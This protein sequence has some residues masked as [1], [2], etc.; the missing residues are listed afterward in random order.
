MPS[1]S[2]NYIAHYVGVENIIFGFD[3]DILTVMLVP[4][5]PQNGSGTWSLIHTPLLEHERLDEA[6]KRSLKETLGT[7]AAFFKQLQAFD[8]Q[9]HA[10]ASP[11]LEVVYLS[12]VRM[13]LLAKKAD[14]L[15]A[16]KYFP[17]DA[18]PPLL[19]GHEEKILHALEGL[20]DLIRHQPVAFEL[21]PEKF[22]IPQLRALYESIFGVTLD[23]G[24]FSKKLHS[25]DLLIRLDEKD[26]THSRKGAYYYRYS[27]HR[28]L[29]LV[30]NGFQFELK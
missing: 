8:V 18:L 4:A 23:H 7:E 17:L 21:L 30:E 22:T 19:P 10:S 14:S 3:S 2:D 5:D 26:K 12:L 29:E 13:N 27:V 1:L 25:M 6:V 24:N 16:A 11:S 28:Y 20:K 15:C 9:N